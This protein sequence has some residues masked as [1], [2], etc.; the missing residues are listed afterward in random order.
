MSA[1][2]GGSAS[3]LQA[4][5]DAQGVLEQR[6]SRWAVGTFKQTY[7]HQLVVEG[8]IDRA[9]LLQWTEVGGQHLL[10]LARASGYDTITPYVVRDGIVM[11]SGPPI[12]WAQFKALV[13][14]NNTVLRGVCTADSF[15]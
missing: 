15:V 9:L 7:A 3:Q 13:A 4:Y 1:V 10:Q 12:S 8:S 6:I 14:A 11:P 2:Y 5:L